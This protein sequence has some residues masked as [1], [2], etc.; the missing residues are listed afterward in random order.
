M[1]SL[2]VALSAHAPAAGDLRFALSRDAATGLLG[3]SAGAPGALADHGSAPLALLPRSDEL[4]AVVPAQMISWHSIVLPRL[5]AARLRSALDGILEERVLDEPQ[6]L[7][8]ALAPGASAGAGTWVAACDNTWLQ[9]SLASFEAAGR[10][11][12]RV[13]PEYVPLSEGSPPCFYALGSPG[14]AWLLRCSDDG[15]QSLPLGP[16][17]HAAFGLGDATY[18]VPGAIQVFAEPA[19]AAQAE[20]SLGNKV[21]I[22]Q[23]AQGLVAAARSGWDLAQFDL[24]STGGTRLA[25]RASL[26]WAQWTGSAAWRP[27]RWGL[28]SLLLVNLVGLNAWAWKERGTL[29]DKRMQIRSL[30]TSTFPKIPLVVDAPLQMEREVAALRQATG[31]V[32]S[33][34][35]EPMLATIANNAPGTAGP[36]AMEYA[37]SELTLRG[38]SPAP[39][40]APRLAQALAA[41]GYHSREDAGAWVLRLGTGANP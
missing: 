3:E 4:V 28:V 24:A 20:Q 5:G 13:V 19:V 30:L 9:A 38:F 33:R 15:V 27:A 36:T 26:A 14:N 8:F 6:A 23:G 25:R 18:G 2:I 21:Q 7:H 17:A 31:A 10:I 32:G 12:T 16:A 29:D 1:L 35:L 37:G 41:A 39:A 34:D 40:D 22:R 11:V